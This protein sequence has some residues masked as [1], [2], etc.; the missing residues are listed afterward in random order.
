MS[1]Q[2]LKIR[3]YKWVTGKR[4]R[5]PSLA[6]MDQGSKGLE[7]QVNPETFS[8][9]AGSQFNEKKRKGS[10]GSVDHL[11]EKNSVR[12]LTF[13]FLLDNTGAIPSAVQQ[14]VSERIKTIND[15]LYRVEGTTHEPNYLHISWGSLNFWCR[16]ESMNINYKL[17]TPEGE[18]LRA[19]IN[20]SFIEVENEEEVNKRIKR[21]SPDVTHALTVKGEESLPLMTEKVYG[22]SSHY[23]AVAQANKLIHFRNIKAG[24]TIVFPPIKDQY[25]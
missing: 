2:R 15:T 23:I 5:R 14:T 11:W 24:D 20:V 17:F 12:K 9:S 6:E 22:S 8:I 18:P 10:P 19:S 3:V 25:A 4:Q 21:G 13:E 7:L 1:L 16:L